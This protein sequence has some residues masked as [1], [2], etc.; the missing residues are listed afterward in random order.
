[1]ND[2]KLVI[3]DMDGLLLDTEYIANK[4][5]FEAAKKKRYYNDM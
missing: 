5:W 3:F 1:M 2:I 4:A